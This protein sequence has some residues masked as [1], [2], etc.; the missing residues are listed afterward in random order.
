MY[1]FDK[2]VVKDMKKLLLTTTAV[3]L[4]IIMTAVF[5]AAA[6]TDYTYI[7]NGDE[8]TVIGYTGSESEITVPGTI[9]GKKVTAIGAKAFEGSL[10]RRINIPEG[11]RVIGENA[12]AHSGIEIIAL[13][14]TLEALGEGALKNCHSL[15]ETVVA[16]GGSYYAEDGILYAEREEGAALVCYPPARS[17]K[18][19]FLPEKIIGIESYAVVY[20]VSLEI[21]VENGDL[22]TRKLAE[23]AFVGA[24]LTLF[25][26]ENQALAEAFD[27]L[28]AQGKLEGERV[29]S[30]Q[31]KAYSDITL[32]KWY[33]ADVLKA[34]DKSLMSGVGGGSFAP[35]EVLTREQLVQI[36]YNMS[37]ISSE[38]VFENSGFSDVREGGW[39][40]TAVCWA[41]QS[42]ITSGVSSN[43][44]GLGQPVTR[45]QLA[46]FMMNYAKALGIPTES[47]SDISVYSDCGSISDWARP[48]MMWAVREGILYSTSEAMTLDPELPVTRAVAACVMVN[49]DR[50]VEELMSPVFISEGGGM[51]SPVPFRGVVSSEGQEAVL[52]SWRAFISVNP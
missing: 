27:L 17:G 29:D 16:R 33:A 11:V 44:F 9:G 35:T 8:A 52:V 32:D 19:F 40:Y 21:I 10:A 38:A 49:F 42:G 18:V 51:I 13:P 25:A 3:L 6:E 26:R 15:R 1:Q 36:L 4:I 2:S 28:K 45:Q 48:A 39:Y 7:T 37:R 22:A 14:S 50:F 5:S 30:E 34:T 23:H 43:R 46:M 24:S 12:F 47:V 20:P 41:K 31:L